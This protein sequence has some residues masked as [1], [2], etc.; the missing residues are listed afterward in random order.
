VHGKKQFRRGGEGLHME[1]QPDH[2]LEEEIE[3]RDYG[4]TWEIIRAKN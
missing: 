4:S 2:R 3:G 1:T